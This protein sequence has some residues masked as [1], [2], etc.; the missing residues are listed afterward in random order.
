MSD[1]NFDEFLSKQKVNIKKKKDSSK[2][3]YEEICKK[4]MESIE[5]K[6]NKLYFQIP[7]AFM[8]D[9]EYD[10]L[11]AI[12]YVVK[13]LCEHKQFKKMILNIKLLDPN[14]LYIEWDINKLSE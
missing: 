12:D 7:L 4:I 3:L 2:R 11:F 8:S 5:N 1:L 13:H 14:I 10:P 6:Y 9:L